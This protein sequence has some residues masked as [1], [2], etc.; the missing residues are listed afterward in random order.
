[1]SQLLGRKGNLYYLI[2]TTCKE[3]TSF[4]SFGEKQ[5]DLSFIDAFCN[6][7]R[8]AIEVDFVSIVGEGLKGYCQLLFKGKTCVIE[9]PYLDVYSLLSKN[10]SR[11]NHVIYSVKH[12][13][14]RVTQVILPL[15]YNSLSYKEIEL[16][17]KQDLTWNSL[18]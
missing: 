11:V 1:M 10:T 8:S 9:K 6:T 3:A 2:D 12:Y 17:V 5:S 16:L 7:S 13:N 15:V 4:D 14:G 18:Y